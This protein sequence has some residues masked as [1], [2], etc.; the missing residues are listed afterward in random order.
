MVVARLVERSLPRSEVHSSNP[1]IGK[2]YIEHF[3]S[4]YCSEET[5]IIEKRGQKCYVQIM[6]SGWMLQVM[7]LVLTHPNDLFQ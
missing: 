4:V 1:F 7:C 2:I 5:K 6:P 3:F